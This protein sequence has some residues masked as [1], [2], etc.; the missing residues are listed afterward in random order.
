M[1]KRHIG[2]VIELYYKSRIYA[3]AYSNRLH[4]ADVFPT[5]EKARESKHIFDGLGTEIIWQVALDCGGRPAAII[6]K[7]R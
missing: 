1:G 4:N 5:R 3:Y 2:Y 6:K 7:V